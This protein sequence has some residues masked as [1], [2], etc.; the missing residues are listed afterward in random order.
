[1]STARVFRCNTN[2]Y[3]VYQTM[4]ELSEGFT[5]PVAVSTFGLAEK[6]SLTPLEIEI[7]INRLQEHGYFLGGWAE[8]G[9]PS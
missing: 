1:M 9:R 6:L 3:R 8:T 4:L 5:Q 7:A 2:D